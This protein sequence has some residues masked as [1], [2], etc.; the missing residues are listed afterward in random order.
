MWLRNPTPGSFT[1]EIGKLL[2]TQ[3]WHIKYLQHIWWVS[4]PGSDPS[5]FSWMNWSTVTP[6]YNRMPLSSKKE[7]STDRWPTLASKVSHRAKESCS[8]RWCTIHLY[9]A[10]TKALT[11]META[12][13]FA[14][15]KGSWKSEGVVQEVLGFCAP[16]AS[17]ELLKWQYLYNCS[18]PKIWFHTMY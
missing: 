11:V 13:V 3:N 2:V 17:T 18:P 8:K 4:R 9:V 1:S 6:S 15:K 14:K 10:L 12:C 7:Q 16:C 5:D